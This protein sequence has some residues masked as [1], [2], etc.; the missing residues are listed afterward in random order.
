[1]AS[2]VKIT[3]D[4]LHAHES[5]FN[6]NDCILTAIPLYHI[7]AFSVNFLMFAEAGSHNLLI[8]SPRPVSNLKPAFE[9]FKVTWLTGSIHS[10]RAY[11][12][13]VGLLQ[14]HQN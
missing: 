4:Y 7:F 9:K 12:L 8:P 10:M 14:I 13:K 2:L 1:M 11:W 5:E 6:H 3:G